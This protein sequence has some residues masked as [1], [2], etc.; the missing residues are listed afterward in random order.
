MPL[1]KRR[2]SSLDFV[3]VSDIE[4]MQV[5]AYASADSLALDA[6]LLHIALLR[7]MQ[8]LKVALNV[9]KSQFLSSFEL[10]GHLQLSSRLAKTF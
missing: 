7:F 6:F 8:M 10:S 5:C 2:A 9:A 4:C 3:L 1:Q